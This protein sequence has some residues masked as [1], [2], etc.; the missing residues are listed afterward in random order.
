[1]NSRRLHG[2][3][4]E[5]DSPEMLL[6]AARKAYR[7]GYR[8]ID[9]Y[10]PFPLEGLDDALGLRPSRIPL[11]FL[12]S[13]IAGGLGGFLLLYFIS[14][15]YYPINVAGRPLNSWPAF[16]PISFELAVLSAGTIGFFA[17]LFFNRLPM[18]YHPVFN[19][20]S[21]AGHASHDRFYLSIEASDP[22]FDP[23]KTRGFLSGLNAREV[24]EIGL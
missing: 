18:P 23:Q 5:F 9:A 14:V 1:M 12:I 21:F 7:E 16:I 6:E 10:S 8:N 20:E 3:M 4:A 2:I 19:N 17:M 15:I 11:V 24:S 22:K 13:G